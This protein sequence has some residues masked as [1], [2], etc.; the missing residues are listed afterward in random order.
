MFS[1]CG[2]ARL[3]GWRVGTG[4]EAAAAAVDAASTAAA[5]DAA[6]AAATAAAAAPIVYTQQL[7][8]C[9]T[10]TFNNNIA[11]YE[12]QVYIMWGNSSEGQNC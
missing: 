2:C 1:C 9:T 10:I 3:A 7:A 6:S 4:K 5:V 11:I 8:L 12:V